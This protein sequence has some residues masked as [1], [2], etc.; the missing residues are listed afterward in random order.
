MIFVSVVEISFVINFLIQLFSYCN[1]LSSKS[2]YCFSLRVHTNSL[3]TE[4]SLLEPCT[5]NVDR[6]QFEGFPTHLNFL[7]LGVHHILLYIF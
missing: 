3:L 7:E 4:L 1:F 2:T 5:H 6:I